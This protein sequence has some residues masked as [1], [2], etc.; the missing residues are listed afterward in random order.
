MQTCDGLFREWA[1][2][3]YNKLAW[4]ESNVY[5]CLEHS[6][7]VVI[8]AVP[9]HIWGNTECCTSVDDCHNTLHECL[10]AEL[11]PRLLVALATFVAQSEVDM[12]LDAP[13]HSEKHVGFA[14]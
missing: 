1:L 4:P 12:T 14:I 5:V 8:S 6:C 10:Y 9:S 2:A 11:L 3:P 13:P 7:N